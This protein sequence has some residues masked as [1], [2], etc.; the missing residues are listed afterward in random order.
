[1]WVRTIPS[2][3]RARPR[4]YCSIQ[5]A[6]PGKAGS[7]SPK[8]A[9]GAG[10]IHFLQRLCADIGDKHACAYPRARA[11]RSYDRT[12][13]RGKTRSKPLFLKAMSAAWG[14]NGCR[15]IERVALAH[16][17]CSRDLISSS[18]GG[19]V[20]LRRYCIHDL[21]CTWKPGFEVTRSS[22]RATTELDCAN[23]EINLLRS[24]N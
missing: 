1:M 9:N 18:A 19:V 14:T 24:S 20:V 6:D 13:H 12:S 23:S 2:C 21:D 3:S 10:S 17:V 16:L 5:N 4:A 15:F 11:Q 7:G 22:T 8:F